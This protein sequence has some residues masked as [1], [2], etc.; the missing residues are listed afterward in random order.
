MVLS[1]ERGKFV[2]GGAAVVLLI[3]ALLG[4]DLAWSYW[5]GMQ[6]VVQQGLRDATSIEFDLRRLDQA[7]EA[8]TPQLQKN[9]KTAAELDVEIEFLA[10]ETQ[11]MEKKQRLAKAEMQE[12][13][14]GLSRGVGSI[15]IDGHM[16]AR[17]TVE[18]D[19][20]HRLEIYEQT[21][22]QIRSRR[23]LLA[24]RRRTLEQAVTCLRD[25]ENQQR[26]LSELADSLNAELKLLEVATAT[27]GISFDQ[28]NLAAAEELATE[29]EKRIR[30]LQLMHDQ[31][32][33][34]SQIPV[35]LDRRSAADRFDQ[36]FANQ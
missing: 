1:T 4:G 27:S 36:V 11:K 25:N 34:K 18:S 15:W 9:R 5:Q 16:Y 32:E 24:K 28:P 26:S 19:L 3:T 13:R 31:G 10:A 14:D 22:K 17:A 30:T 6:G 29:I 2:A 23:D 33:L 12:L 20:Q 7:I 35:N 21:D 8:L